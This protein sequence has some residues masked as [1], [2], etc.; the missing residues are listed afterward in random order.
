MSV[1]NRVARR[2]SSRVGCASSSAAGHRHFFA[3]NILL[4]P[5]SREWKDWWSL[6][7][8]FGPQLSPKWKLSRHDCMHCLRQGGYWRQ[9]R[10]G[11]L[12]LSPS[13][14]SMTIGIWGPQRRPVVIRWASARGPTVCVRTWGRLT[15]FRNRVPKVGSRETRA[16][17]VWAW[18]VCMRRRRCE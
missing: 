2:A 10:I 11:S 7:E 13:P 12:G 14:T 1:S 18:P 15:Q 5:P 6:E 17:S 3:C 16:V 9:E 4:Q 8:V